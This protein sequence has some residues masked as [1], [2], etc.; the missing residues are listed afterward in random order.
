[1]TFL[2]KAEISPVT[3]RRGVAAV[4]ASVVGIVMYLVPGWVPAPAAQNV[5]SSARAPYVDPRA[6]ASCHREIWNS[7]RQTGM[8]R[9]FYRP[10]GVVAGPTTWYHKASDSYFAMLERDG[11]FFQRR[12]QLDPAGQPVNVVEK[13]ID[14]VMGS[15]NHARTYLH[16]TPR[17]ALIELP[18]GWYADHGGHWGMNPGYDQPAHN[19][20][21]RKIAYECMF[22]HNGYPQIPAGHERPGA[23]PVYLDPLPEGIDC[24][25]CHGPGGRHVA[26][27]GAA[28]ASQAAIRGAIVNPARLSRERREEVCI[29]CHLETTS[30][31]LPNSLPRYDRG[32]FGYRPGEPLSASWL[33]FD[34][35]PDAGRGDKFE[36]VNA[37]YR[38]WKSPCFLQSK[39]TMECRTCHNPHDVPRGEAAVRLYDAACRTC[40]GSDFDQLVASGRH[41]GTRDCAGCHM[42]KRRTEDVVHAVATDHL[43]QRRPPSGSLLADREERHEVG[44]HAYRGEVVPYYPSKLP[45]TTENEL[46]LALAQVIDRSNP[47]RGIARLA[48]AI[49]RSPGA[50][51]E[52]YLALA[53]AWRQTGRLDRAVPLYRKAVQG[54]SRPVFALQKLGSALRQTGNLAESLTALRRATEL[55]SGN[56]A[57]WNELGLTLAAQGRTAEAIR[58]LEKATVADPDLPEPHNNL[59]NQLLASG[60]RAKALAAFQEAIRLQPDYSDA[61]NNAG[62]LLA[63]TDEFDAATTH[64]ETALRMQPGDAGTRYNFALALGRARQFEAA[65]HQ[66]EEAVRLEPGLLDARLVLG[67]MFMARDQVPQALHHYRE[68]VRTAADSGRAQ[69]SFGQALALSGE[70]AEALP[71]LRKAATA[72]DPQIREAAAAIL[73]QLEGR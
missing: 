11:R 57:A 21:R 38:L 39:G 14:F 48:A 12:H 59:G 64:F 29:Q 45:S 46:Y 51:P 65:Q 56:A 19:G 20:F 47:E 17:G 2:S 10:S 5:A 53:E 30:F 33:F 62:T 35:A 70:R 22:C 15:G 71:H 52:F 66:L 6:C 54:D 34:H 27:A 61:H 3:R 32:V 63:A 37:V 25:R 42:P 31:P 44:E 73:K 40:H 23:E 67:D 9:S 26:L 4:C 72:A 50:R 16:R 60:D 36:I 1:M 69:L 49:A 68:A 7:Y 43:I 41:S 55:D 58:A 24:Q 28:G 13:Q 18:M 8:G